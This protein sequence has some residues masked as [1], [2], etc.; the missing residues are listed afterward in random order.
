[1]MIMIMMIIIM[2]FCDDIVISFSACFPFG[3]FVQLVVSTTTIVVKMVVVS[4]LS[5]CYFGV[6]VDKPNSVSSALQRLVVVTTRK[7]VATRKHTTT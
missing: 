4:K 7:V 3:G 2:V 5:L 1:M 6:C